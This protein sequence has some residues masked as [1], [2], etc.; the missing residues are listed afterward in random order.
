[1]IVSLRAIP[2]LY[3]QYNT[4]VGTIGEDGR[5]LRLTFISPRLNDS[6]LYVC[7]AFNQFEKVQS[8]VNLAVFPPGRHLLD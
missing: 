3:I 4:Q 8:S 1:M 6:G 5:G 2:S 7:S